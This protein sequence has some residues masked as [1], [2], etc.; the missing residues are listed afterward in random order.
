MLN[1]ERFHVQFLNVE[2]LVQ[3]SL[4]YKTAKKFDVIRDK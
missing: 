2:S 1:N 4:K 3:V